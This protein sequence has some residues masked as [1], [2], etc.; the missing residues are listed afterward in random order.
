MFEKEAIISDF[1]AVTSVDTILPAI[2]LL[3]VS[4]YVLVQLGLLLGLRRTTYPK[5]EAQPTVSVIVAARNEES[6]IGRLLEQLTA[7][8]YPNYEIIIVNDRSTDR[9]S[10]IVKSFQKPHPT[11][12]LVNIASLPS[13]MPPKKY[14]LSEGIKLSKGEILCFTDADCIPSRGWI[15]SLVALFTPDVGMVAGYSPYT[16]PSSRSLI[17]KLLY[18]F[19]AYE[20]FK[21]AV[22][23]AGSI[24]WNKGWLC[25]GRNLA[26]RRRV[27]DEV[28]GFELIKKS[29]SGDDD[30][31]LQA[32][33]R[34]TKWEIR[35]VTDPESTVTTFP[36]DSFRSFV[37]QRTRH[38]SA[39]RF[40]SFPM[41]LFF[42]LFHSS[43]LI[44]L[45]GF[46]FYLAGSTAENL[47][48][49]AFVVKLTA[50]LAVFL[51]AGEVLHQKGFGVRFL[52]MEI[53]YIFYNT[54]IG[55]LGF[56]NSFEWKP[57]EHP[58]P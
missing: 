41:K 51:A 58:Q 35:Y 4:F 27:Y 10:D 56:I 45:C 5:S 22:W 31:F 19:I 9:T 25:T 23:S 8:T 57:A 42:F 16:E 11:V 37:E 14:A 39:G 29:V 44:L 50:D 46:L 40:F 12:Q 20:E 3:S 54:F 53:L 43:N 52:L 38:F 13:S 15:S 36:P 32:V 18:Q 47:A 2:L 28:G 48:L 26:Y 49:S 33:R 55:P 17:K 6:N 7:Q 1:D 24:G 30:L 21:G 34:E